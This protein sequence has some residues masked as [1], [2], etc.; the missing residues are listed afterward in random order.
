VLVNEAL[1]RT[2]T[3]P[4]AIE[5][6]NPGNSA[7]DL[8]GWYLTD[9]FATP[10]K[11]RIPDGTVIGGGSYL[12]FD[13][14]QF[15]PQ[16]GNPASFALSADGD[17]VYPFCAGGNGVLS[18]YFHGFAFGAAEDEISFGRYV[19]SEGKEQFVP[20]R[21]LTLN[22]TN[23]GPKVGPVVI[24]EIMYHPLDSG[25]ADN[26]EDEFIE[27]LNIT[28]NAVALFDPALPTNTW[29]VT[30]GA[31]FKFPTNV[32]LAPG[33]ALLVV[34][35]SPTDPAM[36]ASFQTRFDV[37]SNVQIFGPLGGK[38]NNDSDTLN[39]KKPTAPIGTAVP[40]ATIDRV[41]YRDAAPWP[42][43]ADGLGASLQRRDLYAYGNDPTNWLAARPFPGA[44]TITNATAPLITTQPQSRALLH[45]QSGALT[46][47]VSGTAPFSFQWRLNGANLPG[48]TSLTLQF[49]NI[50][51]QDVG[52]YQLIV[53]NAGGSVLSDIAHISV[54][55]PVTIL[56]QPQ[57]IEVRVAPDPAAA[58]N[59]NVT[60]TV[61][62]YSAVP[63]RYQWRRNG[64]D[65]L[66]ATNSSYTVVAVKTNDMSNFSVFVY[67]DLSSIESV[68]VGLFPL[69]SPTFIESPLPQSVVV[70]GRVTLSALVA[71]F[72]P[73]FTF[74]WRQVTTLLQSNFQ[75]E[76]VCF[77]TFNA[78]TNAT[79]TNYRLVVKNRA[80]PTGRATGFIAITTLADSDGDGIPDQWE[81][82]YR[83]NSS[84]AV[85]RVA[86]TDGDGMLNWQ[87]Y[88][89]GTD[90]TNAL[91]NLKITPVAWSNG[92]LRLQFQAVSNKTYSVQYSSSLADTN[93][94][95]LGR[96]IARKTNHVEVLVDPLA[97]TNRFYKVVTPVQ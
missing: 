59:T 87:E 32:W 58:P 90:P 64:L 65:I 15:N 63:I 22:A 93:W 51:S 70:G 82:L 20:Q 44:P 13:E 43:T 88:I 73:P 66:N 14:T 52:D 91:S 16:P 83:L 24:S 97:N 5:L 74:E 37:A 18:G 55:A 35:F 25:V 62:A 38:L 53:N 48:A 9:D 72:P 27:L 78:P 61:S 60:F 23:A 71:G 46:P 85:D 49:T 75:D 68:T 79:S 33:E 45:G 39:L 41:E 86:D 8:S 42:L 40:Y 10:H 84:N 1:T 19:T 94:P 6:Y 26:T 89:A 11:F 30:G 34:N 69:I 76:A 21:A 77:F 12:V 81:N 96:M 29:H 57:T 31:D 36:L 56:Q 17:E 2:L 95:V 7:V 28:T 47:Q 54:R 50:Q 92:V 67:D 80:S 3:V 4:D